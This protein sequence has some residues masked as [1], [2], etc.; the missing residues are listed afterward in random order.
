MLARSQ[1]PSL[2]WLLISY[3]YAGLLISISLALLLGIGNFDFS[4]VTFSIS[5][6]SYIW[7]FAV[8]L[9]V[10][11]LLDLLGVRL[12]TLQRK[13][14]EVCLILAPLFLIG[15]QTYLIATSQAVLKIFVIVFYLALVILG[16]VSYINK[17]KWETE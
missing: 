8:V 16:L 11:A 12:S 5:G 3:A 13:T 1:R 14:S 6:S 15:Y 9:Q 17:K 7:I 4:G 10:L 2:F